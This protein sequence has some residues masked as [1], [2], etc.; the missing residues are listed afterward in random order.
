M[1]I[2]PVSKQR[3]I[4]SK[5]FKIKLKFLLMKLLNFKS[6]PQRVIKL[7]LLRISR[8]NDFEQVQQGE[9]KAKISNINM[10]K[11]LSCRGDRKCKWIRLSSIVH[12]LLMLLSPYVLW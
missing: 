7:L 10:K 2:F 3:R 12:T 8:Q 9:G 1:P 5:L 6:S 4:E 11:I